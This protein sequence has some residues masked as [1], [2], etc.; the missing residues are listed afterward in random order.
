LL[1]VAARREDGEHLLVLFLGS[2]IGNFDRPAGIKFLRQVRRILQPGDAL[3]LGSD[4][5]KPV[6]QLIPAYDDGLGVTAA[7]NL[8]LLARI[9]RE[10]DADFDLAQFEHVAR[11]NPQ[12]RSVEMHLRSRRNQKVTIPGAGFSVKFVEGETIWTESSHKYSRHEM[13]QI[14][15]AT[16]FRCEAQWIDEEWPFAENLFLAE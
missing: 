7:F 15:M 10:L 14:A 5:E 6:N 1:E 9:N 13:L 12:A 8:N 11:Y 2:T 4:L 3:L 16:G